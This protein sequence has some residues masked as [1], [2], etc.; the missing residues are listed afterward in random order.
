[1]DR[2]NN[3]LVEL[4]LRALQNPAP[5]LGDLFFRGFPRNPG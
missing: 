3:C 1:M 5:S 4:L 2:R